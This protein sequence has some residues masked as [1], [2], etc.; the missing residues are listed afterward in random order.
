[1]ASETDGCRTLHRNQFATHPQKRKGNDLDPSKMG[2][3][4]RKGQPKVYQST[5]FPFSLPSGRK[6]M[7]QFPGLDFST[8]PS[9]ATRAPHCL[10]G[11]GVANQFLSFRWSTCRPKPYL[12]CLG[13]TGWV[14][15]NRDPLL[16]WHSETNRQPVGVPSLR[17]TRILM[18]THMAR[19]FRVFF[20]QVAFTRGWVVTCRRLA[21]KLLHRYIDKA[22]RLSALSIM[23]RRFGG[24]VFRCS[25]WNIQLRCC[26]PLLLLEHPTEVAF[27]YIS[28]LQV[29]LQSQASPPFP[30]PPQKE[31]AQETNLLSI[32]AL[33]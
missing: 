30:P 12:N 26:V 14:F 29:S 4:Q 9:V 27:P 7:A 1:M 6:C 32:G 23:L 10:R 11:L 25:S 33:F 16:A 22:S 17:S 19:Y 31:E 5:G 8:P 3:T 21:W 15:L 13:P 2:R 20:P 18:V 28:L 24:V